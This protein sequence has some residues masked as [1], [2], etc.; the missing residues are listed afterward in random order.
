M[1]DEWRVDVT[2]SPDSHFNL[3][4]ETNGSIKTLSLQGIEI[5][6]DTR[7]IGDG[8]VREGYCLVSRVASKGIASRG[9]LDDEGGDL[10]GSR[11]EKWGINCI[12]CSLTLHY[13]WAN[14]NFVALVIINNIVKPVSLAGATTLVPSHTTHRLP[15]A[16]RIAGKRT[17]RF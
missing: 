2:L 16:N 6:A 11:K 10:Q 9:C 17:H 8:G 12:Q 14:D 15:F 4:L 3:N 1:S 13:G 7:T 5:G